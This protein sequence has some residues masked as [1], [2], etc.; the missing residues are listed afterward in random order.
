MEPSRAAILE[1][2]N[3]LGERGRRCVGARSPRD[4]PEPPK[5]DARVFYVSIPDVVEQMVGKL[6]RAGLQRRGG[7]GA[8]LSARQRLSEIVRDCRRRSRRRLRRLT[9]KCIS[10][11]FGVTGI[12]ESERTASWAAAERPWTTLAR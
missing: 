8:P 9:C 1:G 12:P 7:T 6:F 3:E 4:G 11:S 5:P 10:A 2:R